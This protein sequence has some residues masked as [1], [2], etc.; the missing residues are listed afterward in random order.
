MLKSCWNLYAL[1]VNIRN[2][3]N[4]N[5]RK[6]SQFTL[7]DDIFGLTNENKQVSYLSLKPSIM[8]VEQ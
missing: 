3:F 2:R 7:N 4:L 6:L 8:Y 5:T 1:H